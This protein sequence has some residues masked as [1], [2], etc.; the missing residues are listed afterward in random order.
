MAVR[1]CEQCGRFYRHTTR[2]GEHPEAFDSD[3]CPTH[4]PSR[5]D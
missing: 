2:Y 1:T 5:K 3:L 4:A